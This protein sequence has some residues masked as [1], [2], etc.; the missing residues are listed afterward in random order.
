MMRRN[1]K[2]LSKGNFFTFGGEY[3]RVVGNFSQPPM[4]ILITHWILISKSLMLKYSFWERMI[5]NKEIVKVKNC[6]CIYMIELFPLSVVFLSTKIQFMCKIIQS[7]I[8][9]E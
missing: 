1:V 3:I 9:M 6:K 4:Y 8:E 2:M 5:L 7:L